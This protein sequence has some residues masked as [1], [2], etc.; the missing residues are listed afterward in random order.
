MMLACASAFANGVR[1]ILLAVTILTSLGEEELTAIGFRGDATSN[2]VR[3]ARM[4]QRAGS[5]GVVASPLEIEAIR[6]ACDNFIIVTPGI[7]GPDDESGDQSRTMTAA[8]AIRRGATYIVVGRPITGA[9]DP[10]A[11]ALRLLDTIG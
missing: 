6:N 2:A 4:A 8:E 11:A 7:R 1:P 10:R 9:A 5:D 3:L